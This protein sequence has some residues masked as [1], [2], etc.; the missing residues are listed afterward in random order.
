MKKIERRR[1]QGWKLKLMTLGFAYS[2][3][4]INRLEKNPNDQAEF[5][6]LIA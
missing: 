5:E 2:L 4:L 6:W 3:E 1:G